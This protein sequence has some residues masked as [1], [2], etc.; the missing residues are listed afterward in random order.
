MPSSLHQILVDLLRHAPQLVPELL[1]AA[2]AV[3]TAGTVEAV[4]P[5]DA[6]LDQLERRVDLALEVRLAGLGPVAIGLEVQLAIVPAK[7]CSWPVYVTTLRSLVC[8]RALLVVLTPD[9]GVAR[10]A[11]QPIDLGPGNEAF[12]VHVIGPEQI[13][14]IRRVHEARRAP[15]LAVLSALAHANADGDGELVRVALVGLEALDRGRAWSYGC[16]LMRALDVALQATLKGN[17]QIITVAL[18]GSKLSFVGEGESPEW[19]P[20]GKRVAFVRQGAGG[21]QLPGGG[22]AQ[23]QGSEHVGQGF[24]APVRAHRGAG[25]GVPAGRRP[26]QRP[27]LRA[28]DVGMRETEADAPQAGALVAAIAVSSL[29]FAAAHHLD[30]PW[31][32][33]AFAFRTVAGVGFALVF[34]HRSLAHAVYAHVLYDLWIAAAG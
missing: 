21:Q 6:V 23:Q 22:V 28:Q 11:A 5:L 33:R 16:V 34:W 1:Q 14:R 3:G 29:G 18:D 8:P 4:R 25:R 17:S 30:A 10:W 7:L 32:A 24:L 26:Q 20:D 19:S 2:G 13:P 27:Q 9:P 31:E 15:E 12:C